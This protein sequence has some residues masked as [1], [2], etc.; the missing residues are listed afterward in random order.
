MTSTAVQS[1]HRPDPRWSLVYCVAGLIRTG[2]D[3]QMLLRPLRE[4]C[5]LE[6]FNDDEFRRGVCDESRT[7]RAMIKKIDELHQIFETWDQPTFPARAAEAAAI[8]DH[9][10]KVMDDTILI[11][12]VGTWNAVW[13]GLKN[14]LS[15][16]TRECGSSLVECTT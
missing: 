9:L 14:A 16:K 15:Q 11:E 4:F 5:Q 2:K 12:D 3:A 1:E 13:Y 10:Y 7:Q 6:G 8:L